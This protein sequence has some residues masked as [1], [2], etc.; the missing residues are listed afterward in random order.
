MI[1]R[2]TTIINDLAADVTAMQTTPPFVDPDAQLVVDAFGAVSLVKWIS[3]SLLID[4]VK[5]MSMYSRCS[6]PWSFAS[7]Q[8]S[9]NLD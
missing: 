5:S 1:T 2:F 9:I 6:C 8:F 3:L 7:T 4:S